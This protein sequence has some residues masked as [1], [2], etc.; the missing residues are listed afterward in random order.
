MMLRPTESPIVFLQQLGRGL[1]QAKNKP[2]LTVLDFIG[3]Y[4]NAGRIPELL[5]GEKTRGW[6]E[7][8]MAVPQG[9]YIDFDLRLIDLFREMNMR[10]KGNAQ[11]FLEEYK[12]IEKIKSRRPT[13][14]DLFTEMDGDLLDAMRRGPNP[15]HSYFDWLH[16]HGYLTK[17]EEIIFNSKARDLIRELEKTSM[18][19]LYKMPVLMSFPDGNSIRKTTNYGLLLESWKQFFSGNDNWHDLPVSARTDSF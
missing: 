19:R 2:W 4:H 10:K 15:L 18:S 1:R 14:M 12:R 17:Q 6:G 9:C 11:L 7:R 3:N 13:R 8:G 5:T 16:D